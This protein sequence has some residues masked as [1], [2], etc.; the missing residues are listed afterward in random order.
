MDP[1]IRVALIA[2][3]ISVCISIISFLSSLLVIKGQQLDLERKIQNQYT[4]KLYSLRLEHYPQA[5]ILT[6]QIQQRPKPKK[7]IER[8]ELQNIALQLYSWKTGAV[9]LIISKRSLDKFFALRDALSVGYAEN[10]RFSD[11]QVERIMN[12]RNEFRSSLRQD[13]GLLYEEDELE[14]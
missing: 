14:N 11:S 1:D 10:D 3:G 5:F 8:T 2:G 13:I 7:I 9:S 12:T 4:D 6:E